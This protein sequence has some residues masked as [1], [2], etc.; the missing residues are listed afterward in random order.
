MLASALQPN[1]DSL[2][3]K[4]SVCKA[5]L[6]AS[7]HSYYPKAFAICL[8]QR[9]AWHGNTAFLQAPENGL[10][11]PDRVLYLSLDVAAA[12]ARGGFG[13]ERYEK[14]EMQYEVTHSLQRLASEHQL[15]T[16]N[17]KRELE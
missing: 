1:A 5:C 17:I 6:E 11:A 13:V 7:T 14:K 16:K 15:M 4:Y 3:T 10:P 2:H 12:A 9:I 8:R